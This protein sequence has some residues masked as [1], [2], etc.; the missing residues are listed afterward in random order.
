MV[1]LLNFSFIYHHFSV[2]IEFNAKLWLFNKQ[3]QRKSAGIVFH[4][5]TE[6]NW[7]LNR[8]IDTTNNVHKLCG[9]TVGIYKHIDSNAQRTHKDSAKKNQLIIIISYS[10]RFF[11]VQLIKTEMF[12]LLYMPNVYWFSINSIRHSL[13]TRHTI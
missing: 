7:K 12:I 4:S 6:G 13:D 1:L 8:Y 11:K 3:M 2:N 5:C 9:I 10:S